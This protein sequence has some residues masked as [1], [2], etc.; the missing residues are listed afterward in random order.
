[1]K[2]SIALTA[3]VL[4]GGL[5]VSACG[6]AHPVSAAH[7]AP[8]PATTALAA[9]A[10]GARGLSSVSAKTGVP[11]WLAICGMSVNNTWPPPTAGFGPVITSNASAMKLAQC[12][13]SGFPNRLHPT[14]RQISGIY[15]LS[16]TPAD[17]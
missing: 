15:G 14:T 12:Y 4:L 3:I 7:S 16:T 9:G 2:R 17:R 10:L 8:K 5:P 13:F 11:A 1:M 6:A